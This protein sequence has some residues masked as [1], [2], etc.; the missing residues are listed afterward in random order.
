VFVPLHGRKR[1][2][3]GGLSFVVVGGFYHTSSGTYLEGSTEACGKCTMVSP[4]SMK[5][6]NC[7]DEEK[8]A[9]ES[10]STQS[11]PSRI[12]LPTRHEEEDHT[13]KRRS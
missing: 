2:E 13:K 7:H 3:K 12:R 1:E 11:R 6:R 4:L 10:S 8:I 5:Y 9:D